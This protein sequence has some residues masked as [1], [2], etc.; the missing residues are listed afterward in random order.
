MSVCVLA[1]ASVLCSSI[2]LS[3]DLI[4]NEC[5]PANHG[6]RVSNIDTEPK[7]KKRSN[8]YKSSASV[9]QFKCMVYIANKRN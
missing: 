5:A 7:K 6:K 3:L 4:Q 2:S 9:S 8:N 1:S